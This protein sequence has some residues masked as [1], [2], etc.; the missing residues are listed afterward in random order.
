[1]MKKKNQ[2]KV[3]KAFDSNFYIILIA[4]Y[5]FLYE[6]YIFKLQFI[7]YENYVNTEKII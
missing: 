5:K 6:F 3:R 4:I 1:M 2:K 7:F